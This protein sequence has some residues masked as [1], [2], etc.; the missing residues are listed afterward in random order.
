MKAKPSNS[1][2]KSDPHR[3][4]YAYT[5]ELTPRT[6][7]GKAIAV[8]V[9]AALLSSVFLFFSLL[10]A[11]GA[12][13]VALTVLIGTLKYFAKSPPRPS[14]KGDQPKSKIIDTKRSGHD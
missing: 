3:I 4:S 13:I 1:L 12:A 14:W 7:W 10:V 8:A 6:W 5:V 11:I 2:E 9:V